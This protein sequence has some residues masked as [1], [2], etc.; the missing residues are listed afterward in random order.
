MACGA[1]DPADWPEGRPRIDDLQFVRQG[2]E[3]PRA[4]EFS[5]EFFDSD[6]DSGRGR[7]FLYLDGEETA[8]RPMTDIFSASKP[9]LPIDAS[10]GR[11][12][13]TIELAGTV[14]VGQKVEL[15]FLL[16]DEKRRRSN[17]PSIVL[18]ALPE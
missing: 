1:D 18:E 12:N 2:P 7:L 9:P 15:T 10:S 3:N 17:E 13:V 14:E 6:G 8:E 11:F 5:L 4:L 16:E